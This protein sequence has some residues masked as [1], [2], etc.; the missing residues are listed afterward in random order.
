[1]NISLTMSARE[2]RIDN[3]HFVE[4]FGRLGAIFQHSTHG[5]ISINIGILSLH[6]GVG[7]LRKRNIFKRLNQTTIHVAGTVAFGTIEYVR[8]GSLHKARFDKSFLHQILHAFNRRCTFDG[9]TI[10]L[11]HNLLRNILG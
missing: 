6:V 2:L 8:L 9:A 3:T 11:I 4:L 1:M 7:C 10:Q 5:G